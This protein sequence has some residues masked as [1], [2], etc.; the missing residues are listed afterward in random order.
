M[1]ETIALFLAV[2][3]TI[4]IAL[5]CFSVGVAGVKAHEKGFRTG[6]K[7]TLARRAW[8]WLNLYVT[9]LI[10]V[11]Y[12]IKAGYAVAPAIQVVMLFL[13]YALLRELK[14]YPFEEEAKS[15]N[16]DYPSPTQRTF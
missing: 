1:N 7:S 10:A 11:L 3:N 13:I 12:Q 8:G 9:P 5:I 14:K 4:W 16:Q 6:E 15:K 2:F